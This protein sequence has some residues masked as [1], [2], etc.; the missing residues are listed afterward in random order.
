ME[1][2][3]L[4]LLYLFIGH[5]M[6]RYAG[7]QNFFGHLRMITRVGTV[8]ILLATTDPVGVGCKGEV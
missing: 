1:D 6:V 3:S 5:K 7:G 2:P 4:D 8:C